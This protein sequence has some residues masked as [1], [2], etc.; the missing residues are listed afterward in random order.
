MSW[1]KEV[2][3]GRSLLY[4][5]DGG[6]GEWSMQQMPCFKAGNETNGFGEEEKEVKIFS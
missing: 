3:R 2:W 1:G 4:T 6:S 5:G